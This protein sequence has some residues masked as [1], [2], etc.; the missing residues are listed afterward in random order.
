MSAGDRGC[1]MS[2][3]LPQSLSSGPVRPDQPSALERE[4]QAE[5]AAALGRAGRFVEKTV[6]ALAGCPD[7]AERDAAVQA[8]AVA[9]HAYFIQR[10]LCGLIDHRA[11]IEF[12]A[13]PREVLARVGAR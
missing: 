11:V 8:A 9:T 2:F 5:A 12:Y 4:L 10:E 1:R 7:A 3:R 6:A 13:I